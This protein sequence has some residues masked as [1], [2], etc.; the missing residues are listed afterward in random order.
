M[1]DVRTEIE[2]RPW[3]RLSAIF[4]HQN[5]NINFHG[6]SLLGGMQDF[7]YLKSNCFE[8]TFE[9]SCCKYPP[10][11][12]LPEEWHNNKES[13][14]SF[15]EAT[16]WGVKGL[17]R[18]ETGEPVLDAD[19]VVKG[20]NHNITTSNRGEYWRLLL[21]GKYEMYANAFGFY[22]SEVVTVTVEPGKTTIQNFT[23]AAQS[24]KGRSG[25]SKVSVGPTISFINFLAVLMVMADESNV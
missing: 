4:C 7:N 2:W 8:V 19:V 18:S 11:E 22:P 14:L 13:L 10:A 15:M 5:L 16:H 17:V 21:P 20:I 24:L 12:K 23:L 1:R 6:Y 9:L 3:G 25:N